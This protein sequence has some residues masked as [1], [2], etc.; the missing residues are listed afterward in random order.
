MS[1]H[2]SARRRGAGDTDET[3]RL[4]AV[5]ASQLQLPLVQIARLAELNN[6]SAQTIH[7]I[8]TLSEIAL[9]LTE[10]F[11][12][13]LYGND[14]L[15]EPV[16]LSSVLYNTAHRLEKMADLYH[17]DVQLE[18]AGHYPPVLANAASLEAA[19]SSLGT[20][21]IEAQSNNTQPSRRSTVVLAAHKSRWG[22]VAGMY[23]DSLQFT[24]PA[25]R[26][27]KHLFGRAHQPLN[28]SINSAGAGVFLANVILESV[29]DGLHPARYRKRNGL[30]ATLQP[31][32]QLALV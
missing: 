17:C 14:A 30:A 32:Q 3:R 20:V 31:S 12:V 11:R 1:K 2:D 4:L 26:R 8:R 19:F 10:H 21:L 15:L 27:A 6:D 5:V 23:G 28:Q 22:L 29:A 18:L 9:Q 13:T 7:S 16:S 25:F 24:R